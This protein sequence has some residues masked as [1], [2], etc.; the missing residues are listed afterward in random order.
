MSER[1]RRGGGRGPWVAHL[2][3]VLRTGEIGRLLGRANA[4]PRAHVNGGG[5]GVDQ[6]RRCIARVAV[7]GQAGEVTVTS[8]TYAPLPTH[9]LSVEVVLTGRPV[10]IDVA[11]VAN[12]G[13]SGVLAI[14]VLLRGESISGV[15]NGIHYTASSTPLGF[16][17]GDRVMAPAPGRAV[18]EVVAKRATA[19]G[20]IYTGA[21]NRIVLL[22]TEE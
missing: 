19:D 14:D 5:V 4:G 18:V 7:G 17:G 9:P 12:A 1:D 21:D 13:A 16:K 15:A 20:T 8:T 22:V 2:E 6:I 3:N 10:T 11:G